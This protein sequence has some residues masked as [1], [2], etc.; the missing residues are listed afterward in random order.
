[1]EIETRIAL[2]GNPLQLGVTK[3]GPVSSNTCPECHGVLVRVQDGTI[4]RYRCH[5]GHSFAQ[6]T[7][8][9]DV[10]AEIL[11]FI[12]RKNQ[13]GSG[14]G[15][16]FQQNNESPLQTGCSEKL[17]TQGRIACV[18][19]APYSRTRQR[20]DFTH[21]PHLHAEMMRFQVDTNGVRLQHH[22][23][24]IRNLLSN[25]FLHRKTFCVEPHEARQF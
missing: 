15:F 12:T 14:A 4:V 2:E 25:P 10:K 3:L 13:P 24:R 21:A 18:I 8:L 6:E 23:E 20:C 16:S 5:T 7:L 9:A 19:A 22:F 1:M 11:I 17:G